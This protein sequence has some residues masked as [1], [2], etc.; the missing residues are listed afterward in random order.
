LSTP[1]TTTHSASE[2]ANSNPDTPTKTHILS[3]NPQCSLPVSERS[4]AASFSK[5]KS[6]P[7][8]TKSHS[9]LND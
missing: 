4:P 9:G 5:K 3:F 6:S 8:A 7:S 2:K 1:P